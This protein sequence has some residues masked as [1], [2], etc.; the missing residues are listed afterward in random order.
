MSYH[1][2]QKETVNL[3]FPQKNK[4]K[5]AKNQNQIKIKI[6]KIRKNV[7]SITHFS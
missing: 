3:C 2:F 6:T 4:I 1:I 5:E 7:M